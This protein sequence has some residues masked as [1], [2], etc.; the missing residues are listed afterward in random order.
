MTPTP[1]GPVGPA[2]GRRPANDD[3]EWTPRLAAIAIPATA[4]VLC[5]LFGLVYLVS[6]GWAPEFTPAS[7]AGPFI[8][9]VGVIV[10]MAIYDAFRR[11]APHT[12]A[13]VAAGL[14]VAAVAVGGA[15]LFS[16]LTTPRFVLPILVMPLLAALFAG[17]AW[18]V[19]RL[20]PAPQPPELPFPPATDLLNNAEWREKFVSAA[21]VRGVH[22]EREIQRLADEAEAHATDAGARLQDEFGD[23]ARYARSLPRTPTLPARRMVYY[24]AAVAVLLVVMVA[25]NVQA[26]RFGGPAIS[27]LVLAVGVVLAVWTIVSAVQEYRRTSRSR[28]RPGQHPTSGA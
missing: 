12:W 24:R 4:A 22:T 25:I 27:G 13:V 9:A 14:I 11:R 21:R 7:L 17:L 3:L 28:L 8:I 23:P 26:E 10:A 1:T 5:L 6:S 18:L 19:S 16:I 20:W 15:F 2:A